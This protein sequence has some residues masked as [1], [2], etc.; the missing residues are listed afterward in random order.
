MVPRPVL[1]DAKALIGC[2]ALLDLALSYVVEGEKQLV[3][4]NDKHM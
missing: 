1:L 3:G 4:N 2:L